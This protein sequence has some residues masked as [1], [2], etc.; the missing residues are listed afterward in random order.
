MWRSQRKPCLSNFPGTQR[1]HCEE[2]VT[3]PRKNDNVKILGL[4]F[5]NQ[6][7]TQT[8]ND[9]SSFG[10]HQKTSGFAWNE[11]LP[12]GVRVSLKLAC[13]RALIISARNSKNTHLSNKL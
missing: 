4:T 2:I 7:E 10:H 5:Y 8:S 9:I 12:L 1:L 6:A 3:G 11:A 13:Q